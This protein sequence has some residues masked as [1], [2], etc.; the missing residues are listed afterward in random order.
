M[1]MTMLNT[2]EPNTPELDQAEREHLLLLDV[3]ASAKTIAR[4]ALR[5]A[6]SDVTAAFHQLASIEGTTD[7]ALQIMAEAIDQLEYARAMLK[8]RIWQLQI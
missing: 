7:E 5:V 3:T 2:P 8:G 4:S 6:S 1:T